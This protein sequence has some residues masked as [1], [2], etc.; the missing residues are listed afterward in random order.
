MI[1]KIFLFLVI[2]TLGLS[3]GKISFKEEPILISPELI[4]IQKMLN[5]KDITDADYSKIFL[6]LLAHLNLS[7]TFNNDQLSFADTQPTN[8]PEEL[9]MEKDKVEH[10]VEQETQ[11]IITETEKII[12]D[13]QAQNQT[14]KKS[15]K[16][17]DRTWEFQNL[18]IKKLYKDAFALVLPIKI[19]Q[20]EFEFKFNSNRFTNSKNANRLILKHKLVHNGRYFNGEFEL[21]LLNQDREIARIKSDGPNTS[22]LHSELND[23][24][25]ILIEISDYIFVFNT[26]KI[27]NAQEVILSQGSVFF[28]NNFEEVLKFTPL[29]KFH[30]IKLN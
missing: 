22:V 1:K 11:T 20:G 18:N 26:K 4:K 2:F 27:N 24:S 7:H 21:R 6:L 8:S 29:G 28:K 23:T 25:K 16:A 5:S 10:K 19:A 30:L 12:E 13:D 9:K 17:K 3:V 15:E 14:T